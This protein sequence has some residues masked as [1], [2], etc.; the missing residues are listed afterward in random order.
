MQKPIKSVVNQ[1]HQASQGNGTRRLL[2]PPPGLV[3][4]VALLPQP[5]ESNGWI[6]TF[7]L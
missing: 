4:V 3:T 6:A 2:R 5:W 7:A 1:L